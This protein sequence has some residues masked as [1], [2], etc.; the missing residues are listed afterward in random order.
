LSTEK[1]LR[2]LAHLLPFFLGATVAFG[3][4]IGVSLFGNSG[5]TLELASN[6]NKFREVMGILENEY[7]DSLDATKVTEMAINRMLEKLDPHSVYIPQ[8]DID[9]S[10]ASLESDFEGI[11]IEFL[12]VHDT[13]Q[14]ISPLS[15]GPSD[16]AGIMPGDRIVGIEGIPFTGEVVSNREVFNRLRGPKGSLVSVD[17]LRPGQKN[18]MRFSM[19]RATIPSQSVDAAFVIQPGTGYL[20][21]SRFSENTY[22]ECKAAL[23]KLKK[24]GAE[25]IILDLRDNPGGYL[26]RATRLADEFL[27]EN[28]LIVFTTGK[29]NKY[30][31][32]YYSTPGGIFEEATLLILVN[33]GSA[34]ASEIIAGAMQD[35]DRGLIVGRRTFGKGLVQMPI[36][37]K[38]GSELRLTISRYFTPSGRNIQ[39]PYKI[40]QAQYDLDL[41]HRLQSGEM[42]FKDSIRTKDTTLYET[43]LSRKVKGGGGIIP[44]VFV[45]LDTLSSNPFII[46]LM[47]E[48]LLH[49]FALNYAKKYKACLSLK[50][51]KEKPEDYPLPAEVWPEFVDFLQKKKLFVPAL[52]QKPESSRYISLLLKAGICRLLAGEEGYIRVMSREDKMLQ[53]AL[54]NAGKSK[55][56]F[57]QSQKQSPK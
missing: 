27:E 24:E 17:I 49:D 28:K 20:K 53:A 36:A 14:V 52:I 39:K 57:L 40:D 42:F 56:L 15:G 19:K 12:I 11:G 25:T 33:E 47:Q 38:D 35:N 26:D 50:K 10:N 43:A 8:S 18:T 55:K 54:R 34:S 37:L 6:I 30:N 7:V 5:Q 41:N 4:F 44:D 21:L 13:V 1:K 3:I 51:L 45:P 29:A 48:N 31:Q 46:K 16:L 22:V 9:L 32:K 23:K 2:L